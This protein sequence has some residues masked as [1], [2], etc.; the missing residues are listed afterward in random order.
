RGAVWVTNAL[1]STV[2][3][4]DPTRGSVAATIPVGSGPTAVAASGGSVWVASQF[5]A[6]VSRIDPSRNAVV[7]TARVPGSPTALATTGGTVWVGLQ[8]LGRHRGGTLR[9]LHSR[10]ITIDPALQVDLQP[11]QA[12]A[13]TTDGLVA[14]NHVPG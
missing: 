13:L 11:L 10:P 14:Y 4:V 7:A 3:K 12:D 8:P 9:L 1:D 5:S 2:S 6:T